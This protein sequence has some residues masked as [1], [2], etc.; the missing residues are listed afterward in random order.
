MLDTN[1]LCCPICHTSLSAGGNTLRC[2]NGHAY[3]VAREGYVNLL[4]GRRGARRSEQGGDTRAM[5]AA[6]R[7]F[8]ERGYYDPVAE[9]IGN[10]VAGHIGM[11][12]PVGVAGRL[13]LD[14]GCGEG[15]YLG[16]VREALSAAGKCE[17]IQFGG[18]DLS[19]EAARLAARRHPACAFAVA[20][21]NHRLPVV[22]AAGDVLLNVF[23][24]RNPAEFRRIIAPEGLL[25]VVI[26]GADHLRELR[27]TLGLLAIEEEKERR[28][29]ERFAGLFAPLPPRTLDYRLDLAREDV[30]DLVLMTP[31]AW[32][33]TPEARAAV[34]AL[35]GARTHAAF[36]ILPFR[37]E[38]QG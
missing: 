1:W 9:T 36:R 37:P 8:L 12:P 13:V 11:L 25:V 20:D 35:D 28:V 31:N 18:L 15:Y 6:R 27:D 10:L 7:R 32:H 34:G 21:L 26:P 19:K 3:D 38:A 33:L 14:L 22:D 29:V 2:P 23:A 5:L 17:V 24:P 4:A 30:H 16:K